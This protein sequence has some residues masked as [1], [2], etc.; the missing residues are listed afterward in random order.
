MKRISLEKKSKEILI[1]NDRGGYT[2]PTAGLYPFQWNW[3]TGFTALGLIK[4]DEQRA[5]QELGKLFEGQWQDGLL[6]HIIFHQFSP[7]YYPGPDLWGIPKDVFKNKQKIHQTSGISQPPILATVVKIILNEAHDKDLALNSA[8][9]L[10]PRLLAWNRWWW[11]KRD[12]ESTGLSVVYHPWET[13]MDN[14]P[15]WDSP[16]KRI[17]SQNNAEYKRR[18]LQ[19]VK[20]SQRP[21]QKDYDRY[22]ALLE[23]FRS[24]KYDPQIL[25]EKSP[26]KVIDLGVNSLLQRSNTDLLSLAQLFGTIEEQNEIETR[27]RL[28]KKA[29]QRLWAP[30]FSTYLNWDCITN[31]RIEIPVASGF[32][33]LFARVPNEN[34]V[35]QMTN[36]L[37]RWGCLCRYLVPSCSPD[38]RYF[39]VKRYWRGPVWFIVNWMIGEGLLYYGQTEL[40]EK[41]RRDSKELAEK[42]GFFEYY[43]PNDSSGLGGGEFSW[44]AAIYLYWLSKK[45]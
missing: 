7:D 20:K 45:I 13:G 19:Q 29:F 5:W 39:E 16:L 38:S 30:E 32:L 26:F 15:A 17:E 41:I 25:Y 42:S 4:F 3:D 2:V 35:E 18:D 23:F 14:S 10:Y 24:V 44:T 36:E 33:A 1:K 22:M 31:T 28:T 27:I 21:S 6:P 34:Q 43:D 40:S 8:Q 9:E 12:P 11:R 37:S